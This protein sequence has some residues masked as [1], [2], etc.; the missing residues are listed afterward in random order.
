MTLDAGQLMSRYLELGVDLTLH[1]H[2]HQPFL[3][4][5]ARRSTTDRYPWSRM[6]T[7]HGLGSAGVARDHSGAIGRNSYSILEFRPGRMRVRTRVTSQDARRFDR[8]WEETIEAA[9]NPVV[10]RR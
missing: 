8:G 3:S 4:N 10:R 5:V 6:L 9:E 2:M 1:G 7:V